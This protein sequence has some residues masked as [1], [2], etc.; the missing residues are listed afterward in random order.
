MSM[1]STSPCS[2]SESYV[3]KKP[4]F[5]AR[6]A[7]GRAARRV[8][9]T[10]AR[11]EYG[12]VVSRAGAPPERALGSTTAG[13]GVAADVRAGRGLRLLDGHRPGLLAAPALQLDP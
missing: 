9:A 4:P 12:I 2:T 3:V 8:A 5:P 11:P 10:A 13:L 6:A 1:S 7:R